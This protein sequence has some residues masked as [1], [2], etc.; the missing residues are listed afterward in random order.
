MR[1]I[2]F[3]SVRFDCLHRQG[4][5]FKSVWQHAHIWN[6]L[7]IGVP[8][9][10][11]IIFHYSAS[12]F[13]GYGQISDSMAFCQSIS[14]L[15]RMDMGNLLGISWYH[16]SCCQNHHYFGSVRSSIWA[17]P[18]AKLSICDVFMFFCECIAKG[19]RFRLQHSRVW[20]LLLRAF[21]E[22]SCWNIYRN[23]SSQAFFQ[24]NFY[25]ST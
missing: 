9:S 3:S 7:T 5:G 13:A 1:W 16:V 18:F 19:S 24:R 21:P 22:N 23:V 2:C 11:Y 25:C 4:L 15:R 17:I 14:I 6:I 8:L 20:D 10:Y 12:L